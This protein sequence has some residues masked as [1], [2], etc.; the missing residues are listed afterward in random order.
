[1]Y[2][3]PVLTRLAKDGSIAIVTKTG[4]GPIFAGASMAATDRF[5]W[6]FGIGHVF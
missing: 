5:K 2:G 4:L 1:M 6:W 3:D